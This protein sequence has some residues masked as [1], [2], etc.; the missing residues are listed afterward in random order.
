MSDIATAQIISEYDTV[1]LDIRV[2]QNLSSTMEYKNVPNQGNQKGSPI[3]SC[4]SVD[5]SDQRDFI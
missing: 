2:F 5:N 1:S 3:E 4:L